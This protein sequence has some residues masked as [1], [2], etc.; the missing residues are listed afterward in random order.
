[1]IRMGEKEKMDRL[2]L[3]VL[4]FYFFRSRKLHYTSVAYKC[5]VVDAYN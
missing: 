2:M 1:M 4:Y 3:L 5:V